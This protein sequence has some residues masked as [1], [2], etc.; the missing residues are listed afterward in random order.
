MTPPSLLFVYNADSGVL[1]GLKDL[2]IKTLTPEKYECQL[3]AVTYGFAGMKREWRGFLATL[4]TDAEFLH[5]DELATRHGL[6][7]VALPA[8][9]M[10]AAGQ[11][12]P[13][14]SAEQMG[15]CRSLED[16]MAL[17]QRSPP[18]ESAGPQTAQAG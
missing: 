17:V 1:N 12:Q 16:L 9:F 5:R 10:L 13:W 18:P 14:L 8:A 7:G 15:A 3:C 4:G 6:T 2:F 11:P